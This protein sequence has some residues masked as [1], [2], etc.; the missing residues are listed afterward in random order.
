M[1]TTYRYTHTPVEMYAISFALYVFLV[2]LLVD[3]IIELS[4]ISSM[5]GWLHRR[6]GKTF[7]FQ[8]DGGSNP[9]LAGIYSI[10]G[11]PEHLLVNQG[12]TSNGA[13]GTAI[14]IVGLGGILVL[15]LRRFS[16]RTFRSRFGTAL[17]YIWLVFTVLSALL[18][19]TA[20]IYT[21]TITNQYANQTIEVR[22]AALGAAPPARGPGLPYPY[23]SWT[24]ENWF[25]AI[26]NQLRL[27]S[28]SDRK[29][30]ELRVAIM[31]GWRWNLIPLFLLGVIV[32][33]LAWL[34]AFKR[35]KETSGTAR[36]QTAPK[37]ER[38]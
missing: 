2:L 1:Q 19:L 32:A 29:D 35:K 11:K 12:H 38:V 34:E 31:R 13:A 17:Y 18:A 20:L 22:T 8:W 5:V 10:T 26:L 15:C 7:D 21:F 14:V 33:G 4:F 3:G 16:P 30:I 37:R 6:A 9:D 23:A 25:T 24:P 36:Y 28:N 27:V